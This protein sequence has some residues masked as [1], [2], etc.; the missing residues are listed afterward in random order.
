MMSK[1]RTMRSCPSKASSKIKIKVKNK[2][3]SKRTWSR[4]KSRSHHKNRC[5]CNLISNLV[6]LFVVKAK[7][8][9]TSPTK[10]LPRCLPA[11]EL[12]VLDLQ[13]NPPKLRRRPLTSKTIFKAKRSSKIRITTRL[14]RMP[15][16]S[17]TR[18]KKRSTKTPSMTKA[19]EDITAD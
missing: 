7:H 2:K 3:R 12:V 13:Q 18:S 8:R 6:N 11:A 5:K 15:K 4:I 14:R 10:L 19:K 9:S 1:T 17:R 16:K